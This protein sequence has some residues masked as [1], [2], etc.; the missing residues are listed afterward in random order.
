MLTNE[1]LNSLKLAEL[2]LAISQ[3][4]QVTCPAAPIYHVN[5]CQE[6]SSTKLGFQKQHGLGAGYQ[7]GKI[8]ICVPTR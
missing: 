6:A 7:D 3:K 4:L 2:L 1:F 5:T 8:T